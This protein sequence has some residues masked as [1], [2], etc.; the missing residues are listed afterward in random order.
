MGEL[1]CKEIVEL[2]TAYLENALSSE[3]RQRFDGHLAGCEFCTMYL[4]QMRQTIAAVGKLPEE[5][6]SPEALSELQ[7]AFRSFRRSTE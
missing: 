6:V 2:V 1:T 5:S 3:D 7:N 4:E